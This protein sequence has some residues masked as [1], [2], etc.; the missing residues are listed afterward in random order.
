MFEQKVSRLLAKNVYLLT[1]THLILKDAPLE[2]Q[3]QQQQQQQHLT[4]PYFS[5]T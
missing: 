2:Q 3:Q 1:F 5:K 4:A